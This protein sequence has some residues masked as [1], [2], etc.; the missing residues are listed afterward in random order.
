MGEI[1]LQYEPNMGE[2]I[3]LYEPEIRTSDTLTYEP[4]LAY[5]V[6]IA[7]GYPSS[8]RALKMFFQ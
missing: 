3:A 2:I 7:E 1:I 6:E 5:I 4:S 8:A